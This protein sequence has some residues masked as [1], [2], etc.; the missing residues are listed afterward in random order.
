[1]ALPTEGFLFE[2][3][4]GRLLVGE[5]PFEALPERARDRLACYAPDFRL[6]DPTPWLHP[7]SVHET[8][9]AAL[10]RDIGTP[11]SPV[12][13]WQEPDAAAYERAFTEVM[14]RIAAGSLVKAVPIVLENGE[15]ETDP[16]S[17]VAGLVGAVLAAPAPSLAYGL[18]GP[19]GGMV[20]ASPEILFTH[21][22]AC[23]RTVAVA[24]TYPAARA[25]D[26][27][28]DPKEGR[29]HQNVVDDIAQ[30]LAPF[31][32]VTVGT[33]GTLTLPGLAHLKTDIHVTVPEPTAFIALVEALHPTAALGVFPRSAGLSVLRD[34]GPHDRGRFGAPFGVEWPDGRASVLVAIRNV[35]WSGTT[36]LLGAGAGLIAESRLA[37]EWAELALKRATVKSMFGL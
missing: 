26:I 8:T 20:G 33:R 29:E 12:A 28:S 9:R 17:A 10:R 30:A 18:W 19:D 22:G 36:V 31:G 11:P 15:W 4:P 6:S 14:R 37:A 21:S 23:V 7:A 32:P 24:G 3:A 13:R 25:R 5:G 16:R 34:D 2:Y 35:Q 27:L 1:M